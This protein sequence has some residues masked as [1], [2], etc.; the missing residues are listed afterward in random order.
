MRRHRTCA[1]V[2]RLLEN[3][4]ATLIRACA[5]LRILMYYLCTLRFLRSG[6]TR[7]KAARYVFQQP[8]RCG[9]WRARR[10]WCRPLV[11]CW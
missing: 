7:L 9:D 10:E 1:S 4:C 11:A 3:Y 5:V 6:R 2:S 8:V